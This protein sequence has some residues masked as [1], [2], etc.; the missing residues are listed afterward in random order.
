VRLSSALRLAPGQT[1]AFTGAGGKTAA[2]RHLVQELA[3]DTPVLLTTTTRLGKEQNS[4][5]AQHLVLIGDQPLP[6]LTALLV[7]HRSLLVT[8][9][10]LEAEGKWTAPPGA[11]LA[12]LRQAALEAGAV[13]LVEADGARGRSLKAP[14]QHE[15]VV[16]DF[17]DLVVPVAGLDAV[18][19]PIDSAA[20]HRPERVSDL[21]GLPMQERL[22][23]KH[24]ARVLASAQGGLKNVPRQAAVRV[25][26]NKCDA[27]Q[28][29][30][31]GRKV[32]GGLLKAG[33][34]T[35]GTSP[36]AGASASRTSS[37]GAPDRPIHPIQAVI[38]ASLEADPPVREV[39]GRVAGIVL[40]AG[41]SSRLGVPKQLIPWRGR[42]L[43]WHAAQAARQ[44]GLSPVIV[45]VGAWAD[46]VRMALEGEPVTLI[47]NPVWQAGQSTS[48]RLGLA[49]VE[50]QAE[51]VAFL[52]S[53]TPLVTGELI[54][55]LLHTHQQTLAPLVAPRAGGRRANPVLFDRRTF[56]D[57][58]EL[59]GDQGGRALFERYEPA[60]VDWDEAVLLDLD[61]TEDLQRLRELE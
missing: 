48:V 12:A 11:H 5:A 45:V 47:E 28:R 2:L 17:T 61:T 30:A 56:A 26:L 44:A 18:G 33:G 29:L 3:P 10:L 59:E 16:P 32:A 4:L 6:D 58:R 8:G 21:L 52:L 38:L 40:A 1:V 36:A 15:P 51:A 19:Q 49:E 54:R 35:S 57:L 9:E 50:A 20:V 53:D 34:S 14:A 24:L 37:G 7:Q 22:L 46:Q 43:V 39:H 27:E 55:Q 25:L 60:W 23:P 13:L 31:D 41:E 42:P